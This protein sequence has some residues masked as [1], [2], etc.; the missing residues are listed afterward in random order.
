MGYSYIFGALFAMGLTA[1]CALSFNSV[2]SSIIR[3]I[4][5]G[6]IAFGIIIASIRV[7]M[8]TGING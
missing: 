1:I 5:V 4:F 6:P 8:L 7:S 3:L 2:Q